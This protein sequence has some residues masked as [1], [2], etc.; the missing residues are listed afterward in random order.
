MLA[1]VKNA[2]TKFKDR[3]AKHYNSTVV[4]LALRQS[5]SEEWNDLLKNE[6][7]KAKVLS[8]FSG[9]LMRASFVFLLYRFFSYMADKE[10]FWLFS[11]ALGINSW[12]CLALY[13]FIIIRIFGMVSAFWL[14][15][16]AY[17]GDRLNKIIITIISFLSTLSVAYGISVLVSTFVSVSNIPH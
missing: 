17:H 2:I 16:T 8:D 7:E 13:L 14:K 5:T 4:G 11:I 10:D 9:M 12:L 6:F 15:D 1:R 3:I